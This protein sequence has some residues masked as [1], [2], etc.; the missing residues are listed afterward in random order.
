[1]RESKEVTVGPGEE[2]KIN[3]EPPQFR[4]KQCLIIY[5]QIVSQLQNPLKNIEE[6]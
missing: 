4:S 2:K 1:M 3:R 6:F 5:M